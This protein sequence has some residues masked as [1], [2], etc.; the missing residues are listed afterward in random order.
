MAR[1][2]QRCDECGKRRVGITVVAGR[3]FCPSCAEGIHEID[4]DDLW[5]RDEEHRFRLY[6]RLGD[7]LTVL[8][9]ASSPGGIG[10]AII[11]I[12]LDQREIHPN[13]CLGDLG[14][15]G[16]LDAVERRWIVSPWHRPDGRRG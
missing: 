5:P 12:D 16:V 8:A 15:T 2:P 14:A 10:E 9:A 6:G 3:D 13:R 11:Q 4:S 7:E 1:R